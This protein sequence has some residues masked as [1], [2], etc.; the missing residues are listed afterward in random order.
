MIVV[1]FI[2]YVWPE[3]RLGFQKNLQIEFLQL[4]IK[5]QEKLLPFYE[6]L[7][8]EH[9]RL[10]GYDVLNSYE[11]ENCDDQGLMFEVKKKCQSNQ[12]NIT[13]FKPVIKVI[14]DNSKYL[15]FNIEM[16]GKLTEL[17]HALQQIAMLSCVEYIEKIDVEKIN[18]EPA[19]FTHKIKLL[20]HGSNNQMQP[21]GN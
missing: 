9:K 6:M 1:C 10:T 18:M 15:S 8:K 11:L 3:I 7:L 14:N 13:D 17:D 2:I 16:E 20:L 4:E 21:K 19:P 12:I 5:K